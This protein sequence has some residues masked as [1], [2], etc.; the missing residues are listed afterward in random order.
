[1]SDLEVTL[2][3]ARRRLLQ[4]RSPSGHWVGELSA[5]ALSTATASC[6][7]A[8]VDIE[9]H[10]SLVS[11]GLEYLAGHQNP[12]GGWGDTA[13]S[14]TNASTTALVWAA[15]AAASDIAAAPD[16]ASRHRSAVEKAE[17]W[18]ERHAGSLG[19]E[20]IATAIARRY[21]KD[22][23][24]SAPILTMCA[25][26]GR[27]GE[28]REAWRHV[29]ELPFELAALPHS[30]YRSIRLPVVSYALPALIAIGLAR[31]ANRPPRNPAARLVRRLTAER[32]LGTLAEIQPGSGGYL[33][34]VPLTSFVAIGLAAAG[35]REH[36]VVGRCVDFIVSQA[37]ADGSW[38]IDANL[39]T[40]TTTLSI[41]ALAEGPGGLAA[42]EAGWRARLLDWILGQ[43]NLREHPYTHAAPGGWAWTD[44]SGGV[45]DADDTAG[46]LLAI[47]HLGAAGES[48]LVRGP[49]E[50]SGEARREVGEQD[51]SLEKRIR[52]A[53]R[54]GVTWLLDLQ[55][56]DGGIPTFC[57]GWGHLPFD[58]SGAD[59]TAHALRAFVAWKGDLDGRLRARVE[60]AVRKGLAFLAAT[61]R[62]DGS[63]A[64]LWFG[65][66][67]EAREEN[68]TYGT[69][70]VIG[71]LC[72]LEGLRAREL[73]G[74]GTLWLLEAQNADGGW[75]G[76]PG[77]AATIEET[78]LA[79]SALARATEGIAAGGL[80]AAG[81]ARPCTM[82]DGA[83]AGASLGRA[84]RFLVER[85]DLGRSFPPS[86]IGFYFARLWYFE[87]L[88]PIIFAAEGL[89]GIARRTVSGGRRSVGAA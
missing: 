20:A 60:K 80:G 28:G 46:A 89:G 77:L 51:R 71:A 21:G 11:G 9:R 18:L 13:L 81:S 1:M 30:W 66:E 38:P 57:R 42:I 75:G 48:S 88:Y 12:D 7:L 79:A 6:A 19:A 63:W 16:I 56:S 45:P 10:R 15:F 83:L 14:R 87:R 74:R 65:N 8:L 35:R 84:G 50:V 23:T 41:G 73:C 26:A 67:G 64:P 25:A 33:E 61:Q 76:G 54:L 24:F 49:E 85:T 17:A 36:P 72:A 47:R 55:N 62:A 70:R 53:A 86:P 31:F 44:L 52:A 4:E 59:L 34:A 32:T 82:V 69:A 40:W 27:L 2:R 5:S 29:I 3:N 37:R 22:R 68:P 39:A 58:R 78:G 43:Q